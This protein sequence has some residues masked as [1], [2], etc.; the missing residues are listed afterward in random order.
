MRTTPR[1][2]PDCDVQ[3]VIGPRVNILRM[4]NDV[5]RTVCDGE[6]EGWSPRLVRL[7]FKREIFDARGIGL[8]SKIFEGIEGIPIRLSDELQA[9]YNALLDSHARVTLTRVNFDRKNPFKRPPL[10]SR[11]KLTLVQPTTRRL[12]F[13]QPA[14]TGPISIYNASIGRIDPIAA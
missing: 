13:E 11:I 8:W 7:A 5:L 4:N 12:R 10:W 6:Y 14:A 1:T 2:I 9:S 3:F